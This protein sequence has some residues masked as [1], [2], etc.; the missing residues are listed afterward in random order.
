MPKNNSINGIHAQRLKAIR[1]FVNFNFDLR[2]PLSKYQ[3]SKI[4]TYYDEIDALTARPYNAYRPR[5]K[6]RL[7][8]AQEFAQHEK[9]LPGLKVAFIPTNGK[10]KPVIRFRNGE[11]TSST[12]HVTSRLLQFDKEKLIN[13][14]IGHTNEIIKRDKKAKRFTILAGKYEIPNSYGRTI[15]AEQVAN[16]ASRYSNPE[17]NN[18]FSNWMH[19]LAA[20]HFKDQ[21][22][23]N[24]YRESK[25]RAKVKLKAARRNKKRRTARVKDNG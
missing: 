5:D 4:K 6:K 14:P 21:A 10:E 25:M 19:G 15:V 2:K 8:K 1:G 22:D 24:D 12:K 3:K 16:L 11:F 20:H 7:S 23:F 9:S 17:S 13:D 18:Y